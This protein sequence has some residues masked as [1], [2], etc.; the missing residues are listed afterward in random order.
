M[1]PYMYGIGQTMPFLRG[2]SASEVDSMSPTENPSVGLSSVACLLVRPVRMSEVESKRTRRDITL[3][4]RSI[5]DLISDIG[6]TGNP[7]LTVC[8]F[9]LAAQSRSDIFA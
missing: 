3:D 4:V 6:L 8:H 5:I 9:S 1:A 2:R 7:G